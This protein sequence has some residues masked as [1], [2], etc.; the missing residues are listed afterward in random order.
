MPKRKDPPLP[1]KEQ[2]KRFVEAAREHEVDESGKEF[3]RAFEAVV[4]PKRPQKAA[5]KR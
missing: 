3:E 2:F 5:P 1:P 4:P